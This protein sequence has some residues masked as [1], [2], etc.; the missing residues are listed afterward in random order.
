MFWL[1]VP[2][3]YCLLAHQ[4]YHISDIS[5]HEQPAAVCPSAHQAFSTWY[6]YVQAAAASLSECFQRG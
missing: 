6:K 1:G 4:M 5:E 3:A 2:P